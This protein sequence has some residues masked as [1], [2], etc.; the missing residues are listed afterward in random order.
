M[1]NAVAMTCGTI[2]LGT[3]SLVAGEAWVLPRQAVTWI[4]LVY[5]IIFVTLV[6][7]LLYMYVL[8][9]W[10]ASGTS[11]GF[12]L[13][14]LVTIVVAATLAGETITVNFLF[15]AALVLVGVFVGALLPSKRKPA[16]I[17]E[18]KSRSGQVL[19]RCT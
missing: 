18:C 2:I 12:V 1:T 11:F 10:T 19:P 13:I 4:A 5:L 3:A 8:S 7:F 14:P 17:E 9:N 15:G 16:E 6:A